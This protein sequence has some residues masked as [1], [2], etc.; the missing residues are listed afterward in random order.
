MPLLI[1]AS[2]KALRRQSSG[3][4]ALRE[5]NRSL[6]FCE[7]VGQLGRRRD[8][9]LELCPAIRGERPVRERIKLGDLPNACIVSASASQGH[10]RTNGRS[11][12]GAKRNRRSATDPSGRVAITI[13]RVEVIAHRCPLLSVVASCS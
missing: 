7:P 9:C 13:S 4:G 2:P 5:R 8:P 11:L 10:D 6:L 3:S 12:S 1:D